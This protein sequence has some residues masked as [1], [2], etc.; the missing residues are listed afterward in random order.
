MVAIA[1]AVAAG[2][3]AAEPGP[4]PGP[5]TSATTSSSPSASASSTS[6]ESGVPVPLRVREGVAEAGFA[7]A[8]VSGTLTRDALDCPRLDDMLL[9][10]PAMAIWTADA[11]QVGGRTYP[12][13]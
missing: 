9:V 10:L 11:V 2:C 8:A 3:T 13:G 6:Q 7:A 1:V 5:Q 12:L 4:G